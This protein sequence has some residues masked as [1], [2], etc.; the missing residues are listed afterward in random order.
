[1]LS[2]NSVLTS[3]RPP[4]RKK[5]QPFLKETKDMFATFKTALKPEIEGYEDEE[6]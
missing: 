5:S 6:P 2:S 3:M 4:P 1:M